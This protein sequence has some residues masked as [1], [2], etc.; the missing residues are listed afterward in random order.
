[1]V[2]TYRV[3]SHISKE[4]DLI[5]EEQLL[6]SPGLWRGVKF[7]AQEIINGINRTDWND[8]EVS[9]ILGAHPRKGE[10]PSSEDWIGN[11]KNVR[12]LT[13]EDGV[14]VEGMYGDAYLYD[15]N[16]AKKLAYGKAKLAFSI[17]SPYKHSR[18]GATDLY[19]NNTAL[20]YRGGCKDAYVQLSDSEESPEMR[21]ISSDIRIQLED[22]VTDESSQGA[23]GEDVSNQEEKRVA[24]EHHNKDKKIYL[25]DGEIMSTSVDND[26][27]HTWIYEDEYTSIAHNHRHI[28]DE[29]N[30]LALESQGHTHKLFSSNNEEEIKEAVQ[31]SDLDTTKKEETKRVMKK[32]N[33]NSSVQLEDA[34][35]ATPNTEIQQPAPSVPQQVPVVAPEVVEAKPAPVAPA[36]PA[37]QAQ[38][39]PEVV[40]NSQEIG[41]LNEKVEGFQSE[42][43]KLTS[44]ILELAKNNEAK[45]APVA[46][47]APVAP[48]TPAVQAPVI[49]PEPIKSEEIK[50][51]A[52]SKTAAQVESNLIED[53]SN[54][55]PLEIAHKRI[56]SKK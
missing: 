50:K 14:D 22:E 39:T 38:P 13:L 47:P 52:V 15:P 4:A 27:S 9:S 42:M 11:M 53:N 56:N 37:V 55:S 31:L 43:T 21:F 48:A 2:K 29:E 33:F 32:Q 51:P 20:V 54:L 5:L 26:H 25:E 46:E 8:P 3:G 34:P 7:T 16:A 28:I 44:A 23:I 49:T 1:M 10:L 40:D 24:L 41:K 6:L 30:M 35:V 17:D 18:Y 12:Y 36:T 19:F 45:P